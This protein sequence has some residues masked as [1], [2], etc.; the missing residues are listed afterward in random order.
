MKCSILMLRNEEVTKSR[1]SCGVKKSIKCV[2]IDN[3]I[4]CHCCI[5]VNPHK[6]FENYFQIFCP[7]EL[8]FRTYIIMGSISIL[9]KFYIQA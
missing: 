7:A 3:I 4:D 9:T 6:S 8:K 2:E 1:S 5:F